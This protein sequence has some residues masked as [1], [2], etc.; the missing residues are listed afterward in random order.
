MSVG[1]ETV[2]PAQSVGGRYKTLDAIRGM[3]ALAVAAYHLG[4]RD[5]QFIP[6][7]Y[8]AVDLF[9]IL[10]GFVIALNYHDKIAKG[11]SFADFFWLRLLRLYPIYFVGL[12]I[13][14]LR[15]VGGIVL[16]LQHSLGMGEVALAALCALFMLPAPPMGPGPY[17]LFPLNI[18]SW[19][20]FFEFAVN[21][22]FALILVRLRTQHLL[23]ISAVAMAWLAPQITSQAFFN[24]GWSWQHFDLGLARTL[25]A[26]PVGM[27]LWRQMR[28]SD[29]RVSWIS[30]A[31]VGLVLALMMAPVGNHR[32]PMFELLTVL[33]IFPLVVWFGV[34]YELPAKVAPLFSYLG[35]I[36]YAVYAIHFPMVVAF[37]M[38]GKR[39]HLHGLVTTGLFVLSVV[40]LASAVVHWIDAPVRRM[41]RGFVAGR[42]GTRSTAT[43]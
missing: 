5:V 39:L 15:Q 7:G 41:L 12:V 24:V 33:A 23:I 31:V 30:L 25:F 2:L 13:G 1:N 32:R 19:S 42:A 4:Q 21:M 36:S 37:V 16:H 11:L 22:L 38:L 27:V 29:R 6:G 20:L 40:L 18:P 9:F 35:D 26:F 8:L 28:L 10:S 17:E 3:A 34:H 43:A 14:C